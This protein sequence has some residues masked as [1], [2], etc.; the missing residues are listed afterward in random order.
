VTFDKTYLTEM[1]FIC[2][3]TTGAVYAILYLMVKINFT[4][5]F[6]VFLQFLREKEYGRYPQKFAK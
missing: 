6:Y 2:F 1:P 5:I 4:Y 3:V